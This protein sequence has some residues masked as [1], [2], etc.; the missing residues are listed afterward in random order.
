MIPL[1]KTHAMHTH[2]HTHTHT[3]SHTLS[4]GRTSVDQWSFLRTDLY[5]TRYKNPHQL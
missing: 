2:T 1:N 5:R 3:H 4:H